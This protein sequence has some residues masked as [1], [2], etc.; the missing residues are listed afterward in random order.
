MNDKTYRLLAGLFDAF[1]WGGELAGDENLPDK[2][3]AVFV[4]NHVGALGPIATVS[5][6]PLRVYPW[7]IGDMLDPEKAPAYLNMDFVEKQLHL[8]PPLSDWLSRRISKISV[9]LLRSA[10]CIGV[11]QGEAL[12]QTYHASV[13]LLAEGKCLLIFPEDPK[14]AF[15]E[16][17][18]MAPFQKGFARLGEFFFERTGEC[19]RFYPLTVHVN[20]SRIK[21]GRPVTFNPQNPPMLERARIKNVLEAIIHETYISMAMEGYMGVPLP[22]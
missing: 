8:R 22:H 11:W 14:Q 13:D 16:Y 5:S 6:L 10:G 7:I 9:P 2:G 4:S 21:V 15:N 1:I 3:P 18:K 19:L 20:S 17:F 12:F